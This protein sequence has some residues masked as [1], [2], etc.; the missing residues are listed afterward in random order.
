[1]EK[2]VR[3]QLGDPSKK[4]KQRKRRVLHEMTQYEKDR[5]LLHVRQRVAGSWEDVAKLW[6]SVQ[7]LEQR[8]TEYLEERYKVSQ[9]PGRRPAGWTW[10]EK[11]L[12]LRIVY[13]KIKQQRE[14]ARE[15]ALSISNSE[16]QKHPNE[17]RAKPSVFQGLKRTSGEKMWRKKMTQ[18]LEKVLQ[19]GLNPTSEKRSRN[20]LF[21]TVDG[22]GIETLE[23]L[24]TCSAVRMSE[25]ELRA[26]LGNF[27]LQLID[28]D[29]VL[30]IWNGTEGCQKC[31]IASLRDMFC[32]LRKGKA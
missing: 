15:D 12:L 2:T 3:G 5:L 18:A 28:L 10:V 30:E 21:V 32:K 13:D 29:H 6:N 14:T 16:F 23:E 25:Q 9:P 19:P 24:W 7:N 1:M 31:S 8:D 22:R 27:S 17:A 4:G 20:D 26:R 11:V